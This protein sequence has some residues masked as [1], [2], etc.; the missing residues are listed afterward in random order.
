MILAEIDGWEVVIN[1]L[2]FLI[3]AG[4]VFG[5]TYYLVNKLVSEQRNIRLLELK[6][7]QMHELTPTKLQAYERLTLF[8]DRISPDNLVVRLSK[9]GQSATQLRYELIQTILGEYNHNISQQIYVSNSTWR[10]IQAVKDQVID[11]IENCYT[12]CK[13]SDSGPELGKKI[14]TH[15]ITHNPQS[16][17]TAIELLKKE[18]DIAL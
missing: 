4:I 5:T 14:L 17:Q 10:I 16:I 18:I 8:L 12:T 2:N 6:K 1:G 7:E 15:T 9:S 13:T 11:T 3:P